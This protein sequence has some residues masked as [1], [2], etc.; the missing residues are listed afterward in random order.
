MRGRRREAGVRGAG[1]ESAG[2]APRRRHRHIILNCEDAEKWKGYEELF[3]RTFDPDATLAGSAGSTRKWEYYNCS[4]MDIPEDSDASAA[5]IAAVIVTGSHHNCVEDID[6]VVATCAF[7][8]RVVDSGARVLGVCFGC[9]LLGRALGGRVDRN[10]SAR[11][12]LGTERIRPTPA[13]YARR[14]FAEA[15][16]ASADGAEGLRE[17]RAALAAGPAAGARPGA[18]LRV[19]ES[20]GY[21]VVELPP[22]ATLLA[23]SASTRS[24]LWTLEGG[25]RHVLA[26]Q[27]HPEL[28]PEIIAEKIGPALVRNG[29]MTAGEVAAA[30][31]GMFAEDGFD[32]AIVV[33]M[34]RAFLGL[35]R[36]GPLESPKSVTINSSMDSLFS[37]V[38]DAV[39]AELALVKHDYELVARMNKMAATKYQEMADFTAGLCQFASTLSLKISKFSEY[40]GVVEEMEQQLVDLEAVVGQLDMCTGRLEAKLRSATMPVAAS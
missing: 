10:P 20:H 30:D 12:V 37:A 35:A 7:L 32:S 16:R 14:D 24:E 6:W 23:S 18:C 22:G 17:V 39:D 13:L 26:M 1:M 36:E 15:V 19:L 4:K 9:Q 28:W 31:A 25:G 34:S 11:F 38:S 27:F 29:T 5:S 3:A 2:P 40:E 21:Q 8:R 33:H